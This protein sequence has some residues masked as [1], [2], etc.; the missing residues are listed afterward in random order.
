MT[1]KEKQKIHNEI[2]KDI[3][4]VINKTVFYQSENIDYQ[5][6]SI[7]SMVLDSRTIGLESIYEYLVQSVYPNVKVLFRYE[8]G[9]EIDEIKV[10]KFDRLNKIKKINQISN[11]S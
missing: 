5:I 4:D 8:K 9:G 2:E 6:R 3:N 7:I 10:L 11:L 1:D